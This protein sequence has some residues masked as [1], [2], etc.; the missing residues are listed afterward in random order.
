MKRQ[1]LKPSAN[2]GRDPVTGQF[3]K[4]WRGGP[5]NPHSQETARLRS[6][7]L[8]AVKEGDIKA[9]V[10]KVIESS[11]KAVAD[12]RKGKS[13]ALDA[14]KGKVMQQTRG[15]ANPS[16]VNELLRKLLDSP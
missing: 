7:L 9:I 15:R 11:E 14:M 5:G 13:K 16:V 1:R 10:K 3:V 2:G 8:E 4:G 12:Y 6:A